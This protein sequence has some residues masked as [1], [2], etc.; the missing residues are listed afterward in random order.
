VQG[1][2]L[3]LVFGLLRED[4]PYMLR[5]VTWRRLSILAVDADRTLSHF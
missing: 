4:A 2:Q 5:Q 3:V 1:I